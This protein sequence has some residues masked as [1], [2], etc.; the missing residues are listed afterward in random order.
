MIHEKEYDRDVL[1]ELLVYDE[2]SKQP[3]R[4]HCAL[5]PSIAVHQM[6]DK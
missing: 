6:L 3:N 5:I 4:I 2:I 1:G